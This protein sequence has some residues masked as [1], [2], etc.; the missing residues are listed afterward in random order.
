MIE[1]YRFLAKII[2][3]TQNRVL[4]KQKCC[5]VYLGHVF[6]HRIALSVWLKKIILVFWSRKVFFGIG[7]VKASSTEELEKKKKKKNALPPQRVCVRLS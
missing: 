3:L 5:V 1:V 7:N 6:V 2:C 4:Q